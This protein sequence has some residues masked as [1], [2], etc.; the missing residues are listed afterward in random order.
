MPAF[1]TVG[2]YDFA[3]SFFKDMGGT[4]FETQSAF[5]ADCFVDNR[6]HIHPFGIKG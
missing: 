2:Y 3:A 4:D 1:V 6:R 5:L